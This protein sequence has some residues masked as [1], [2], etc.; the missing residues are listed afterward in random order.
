MDGG[1]DAD[2][3]RLPLIVIL[4]WLRVKSMLTKNGIGTLDLLLAKQSIDES[5]SRSML[6]PIGV[7]FLDRY[8]DSWWN[9]AG[10][11]LAI[12]SGMKPNAAIVELDRLW[13]LHS[14]EESDEQ[15]DARKSPVRR[16]FET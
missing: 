13:S 1:V 10:I 16:E 12:D 11:N 4:Q 8:W 15:S 7:S 3:A 14:N 6:T 5:L 2:R 9:S